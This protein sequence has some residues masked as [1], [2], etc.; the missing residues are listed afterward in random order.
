MT[1]LTI[2]NLDDELKSLLR[3]Q[4][5]RHGCSMEQEA[6][7][8][9][10]RAVQTQPAGAGFAQRIQRRFAGLKAEDLPIPKR[11]AARLSA[12]PKA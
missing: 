12:A 7:D 4:A 9:L 8:I 11:R 2:R 3:R 6:R 1:N 10:R 5:A